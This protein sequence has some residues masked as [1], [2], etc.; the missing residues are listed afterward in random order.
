[1]NTLDYISI[2]QYLGTAFPTE[3]KTIDLFNNQYQMENPKKEHP[4]N[5]PAVYIEFA[6]TSWQDMSAG[7]KQGQSIVRFHIVLTA[8]KDTT[9]IHKQSAGMQTSILAHYTLAGQ[10]A[11]KLEGYTPTTGLTPLTKTEVQ[12]DTNHD[13]VLAEIYSYSYD[14]LDTDSSALKNLVDKVITDF[15][16]TG[17]LVNLQTLLN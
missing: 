14:R 3:I 2:S 10:I 17:E 4:V 16:V 5:Y 11:S 12:S 13:Q 15:E 7:L 8:M 6:Q 9:N 1:M